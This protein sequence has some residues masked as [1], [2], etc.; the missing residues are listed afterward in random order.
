MKF[1]LIVSLLMFLPCIVLA[2]QSESGYISQLLVNN[3]PDQPDDSASRVLISLDGVATVGK[4]NA[5]VDFVGERSW[6][7]Y[8]NNDS[9]KAQYSLLLSAYMAGVKVLVTGNSTV[10]CDGTREIVRNV[11]F[12]K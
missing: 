4:C 11:E 3:D 12:V 7:I 6:T 8:L 9:S 5:H 2:A 10:Q 1:K